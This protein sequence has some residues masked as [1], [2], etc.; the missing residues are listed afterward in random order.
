MDWKGRDAGLEY[1]Q[2]VE[3]EKHSLGVLDFVW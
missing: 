3:G 1:I 2:Y